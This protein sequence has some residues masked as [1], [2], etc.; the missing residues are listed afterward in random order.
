MN[1]FAEA[2][3]NDLLLELLKCFNRGLPAIVEIECGFRTAEKYL[4]QL[5]KQLQQY[6]FVSKQ[7]EINF[8]KHVHPKFIAES[9]FYRYW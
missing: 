9:A 3:Y 4:R 8:Y 5:E 7:E 2:L 1:D 6:S